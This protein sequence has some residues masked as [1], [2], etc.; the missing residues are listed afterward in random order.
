MSR[1][2]SAPTRP[3]ERVLVLDV[4]RRFAILGILLVNAPLFVEPLWS[5]VLDGTPSAPLD[6]VAAVATVALAEGEF[7]TLFSLLFGVGVA[8]QMRRADRR[9]RRFAPF[10]LRR[11]AVLAAIGAA[12]A[13]ETYRGTDLGAMIAVRASEWR[14]ATT[15]LLLN[16]MVFLIL[17]MFLVGLAAGK[18]GILEDLDRHAGTL[19]RARLVGFLIGV[20]ATMTWLAVRPPDV[21]TFDASALISTVGFVLGAPALSIGYAATLAVAQCALQVPLAAWWTRRFRF[22]PAEWVW[23]S[24]TYGWPQPMRRER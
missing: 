22:G 15:G 4:L 24:L 17:A 21:F 23:R 9:G 18:V 19:R 5:G 13:L 11:M 16:G 1:V 14:F 20:P 2:P 10:F 6:S 3:S 12:T 8:M 7:F